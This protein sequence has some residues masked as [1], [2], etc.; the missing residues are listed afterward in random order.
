LKGTIIT[1][2]LYKNSW[3]GNFNMDNI[4]RS[5]KEQIIRKRKITNGER[6]L[7]S[8]YMN[9]I[10]SEKEGTIK[11]EMYNILKDEREIVERIN[12]ND[13]CII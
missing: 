9:L 10:L 1:Y 13:Q 5:A 8:M 3:G 7:M 12:L 2:Q 4:S 6:Y 11:Q